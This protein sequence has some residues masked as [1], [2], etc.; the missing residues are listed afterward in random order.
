MISNRV[1][2]GISWAKY[3]SFLWVILGAFNM[4][5]AFSFDDSAR[6]IVEALILMLGG[7]ILT[8]PFA[9]LGGWLFGNNN[10]KN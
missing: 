5:F 9:F 8:A 6:K 1:K 4:V 7:P 10:N 2:K 3:V